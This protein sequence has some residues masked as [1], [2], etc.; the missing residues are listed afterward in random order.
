MESLTAGN[1]ASEAGV[2]AF[3]EK[4]LQA[5]TADFRRASVLS[6]NAHAS[7]AEA[8]E[9]PAAMLGDAN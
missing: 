7:S 5:L 3:E 4:F 2:V 1:G 8:G 9:F 6:K